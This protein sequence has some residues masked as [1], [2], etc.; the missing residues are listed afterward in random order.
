MAQQEKWLTCIDQLIRSLGTE[1]H[2]YASTAM[3]WWAKFPNWGNRI[4]LNTLS[5]TV[6]MANM[7][8]PL[9]SE[10]SYGPPGLWLVTVT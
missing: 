1:T 6:F 10:E 7:Y 9:P 5:Q 8:N 4:H 3:S 2:D